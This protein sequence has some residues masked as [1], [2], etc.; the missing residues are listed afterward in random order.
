MNISR[1]VLSCAAL[2]GL[3]TIASAQSSLSPDPVPLDT[4]SAFKSPG[5]NWTLASDIS[6][7]PRHEKTLSAV[8]GTGILANTDPKP[9]GVNLFTSWEHGD[10]EI[11]LEFLLPVGSNS[12]IYLQSRYE[13]Q[14]FDSWGV[15]QPTFSDCGGIYQ[16]Y[17]KDKK[18]GYEGTAPKVNA[19]RAPGLWQRLHIVFKAPR[20]NAAGKKIDNARFLEVSLNGY[21]IHENVEVT[22][23]T[24]SAAHSDEQAL[25]PL[26]IQ[27]DHGSVAFRNI[28][29]KRFR[30]SAVSLSD[31]SY[32]LRS[33][34]SFKIGRY[35]AIAPTR[36]EKVSEIVLSELGVAKNFAATYTG[37]LN[38]PSSGLYAFHTQAQGPTQ[39]TI[40]G[41]TAL[42]PLSVGGRSVPI[43]LEKGAH[44]FRLD[45]VHGQRRSPVMNLAVE[46]PGIRMHSLTPKK[47][48]KGGRKQ[49]ERQL[50]IEPVEDRVRVQRGFIPHDPRKRL[51]AIA[52]GS[53]TAVH[54]AYDFDTASLLHLWN[55]RFLDTFEMWDGR[56][57]DQL[58]KPAGPTLTLPAKPVVAIV[59]STSHDWPN[60]PD[61]LWKP[62]GYTLD[63][64]GQ[65]EFHA[66]LAQLAVSDRIVATAPQRGLERTLEIEGAHTSWWTGV[67]LAE[68]SRITPQ[69]NGSYIIGEREYYIDV[70][71]DNKHAPFVRRINGQDQ[72]I[73]WIPKSEPKTTVNYSLVW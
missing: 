59:Q 10:I 42:L 22:G 65:P 8:P 41:R 67:L 3:V 71:P 35:D 20:F 25:A 60:V 12:G 28:S 30:S 39:L 5:D 14:L 26:M 72:L 1:F 23:P 63:A 19:S 7:D 43:Q 31:L 52:V 68:A 38:I 44:A 55:G 66:H 61:A 9:N 62:E 29:I 2:A 32:A 24:R 4:L 37:Y 40:E 56:G 51:Y 73:V 45:Y 18:K 50:I 16:R 11:D 13:V 33:G 21:L 69:E 47:K 17:L 58:A 70:S 46:G 27:G 34:R 15:A 49:A 54:Y 57:N 64:D 36:T 6:G 48:A 53:P